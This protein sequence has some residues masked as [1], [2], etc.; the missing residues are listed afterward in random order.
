MPST[1]LPGTDVRALVEQIVRALVDRPER[2]RVREVVGAHATIL[3]VVSDDPTQIP[4]AIGRGG[5]YAEAI[6]TLLTAIGGKHRRR[7]VLE[8]IQ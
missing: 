7:Y 1:P 3:E 4:Q 2:I 8:L 5:A 6:R